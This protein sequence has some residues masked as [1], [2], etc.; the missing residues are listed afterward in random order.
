MNTSPVKVPVT[1]F[2]DGEADNDAA[3]EFG[4]TLEGIARAQLMEMPA[5]SFEMH[6]LFCYSSLLCMLI[7]CGEVTWNN[8]RD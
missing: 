4:T 8:I 7:C 5:E 3:E 6:K 2:E 1:S